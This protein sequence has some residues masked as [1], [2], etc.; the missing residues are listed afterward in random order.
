M[1]QRKLTVM[2]TAPANGSNNND[3]NVPGMS[4]GEQ[5]NLVEPAEEGHTAENYDAEQARKKV[6]NEINLINFRNVR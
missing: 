4:G 1:W 2:T 5:E 6:R 3:N